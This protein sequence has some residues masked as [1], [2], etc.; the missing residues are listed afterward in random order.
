MALPALATGRYKFVAPLDARKLDLPDDL[1]DKV[2]EVT[3]IYMQAPEMEDC[4]LLKEA[5]I[6]ARER[7]CRIPGDGMSE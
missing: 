4:A 5:C 2:H 7:A 6:L 3:R 1:A